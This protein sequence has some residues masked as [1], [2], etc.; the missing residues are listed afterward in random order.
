MRSADCMDTI[1][2]PSPRPLRLDLAAMAGL[3]RRGLGDA[4]GRGLDRLLL[5]AERS[6]QRHQ[7][8]ELNDHM[9]RDIGLTRAD[10]MA[11]TVKPFWKP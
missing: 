8:A 5:W 3:G 2:P 10:V 7:L 4:I 6:G 1:Q 11:E 9:L